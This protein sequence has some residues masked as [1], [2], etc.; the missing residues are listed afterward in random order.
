MIIISSTIHNILD[1]MATGVVFA[2][3]KVP[4]IISTN[5]AILLHEIPK[6]LGDAGIL[7]YSNF[8]IWS[9]LFWNSIVN[10]TCIIG[11]VIGLSIGS[12]SKR[13]ESYCLGFVAG[14]FFYISLAEMIPVIIKKKGAW[15]NFLQIAF[16]LIG[17]SIMFGIL[18][19]E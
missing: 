16:I 18:Y 10:V 4:L 17:L 3:R 7:I 11:T 12:L 19:I 9:V 5:L 2:S 13:S 15:N 14:N 1:G 8:N 6:E